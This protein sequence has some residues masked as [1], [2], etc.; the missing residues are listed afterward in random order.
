MT[1]SNPTE[2]IGGEQNRLVGDLW[3][4]GG[5]PVILL[6]GGGQTR[7]AWDR[8]AMRLRAAGMRAITVDQRGHGDSEWV[9]SRDYSFGHFAEDCAA[10][11]RQVAERYHA[12]PSVVG[13]SLGG[14]AAL[15]AELA[16]GPLFE[17]LVLVD[18]TPR[19]DPQGVARIQG[20]MAE[21][22]DEGFAT[23]EE[24]AD[25]IA[26]YLP[27]RK[28]PA[29]LDGLRKN[30]RLCPDGRYRWHWDPAFMNEV[31]GINHRSEA[32]TADLVAKLPRLHIPVLLVRGMHSEV[33]TEDLAREFLTQAPNASSIDVGEA[34]HMVA[35][36]RNDVFADAVLAFLAGEEVAG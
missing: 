2:F 1:R 32:F 16:Y 18:V 28:R 22:M 5:S 14:L 11:A 7:H 3:D 25:A 12:A 27:N 15:G 4:G 30:L 6:H 19:L 8:T 29:S 23:L 13:A 24:A 36:D 10:I 26:R 17:S 9:P 21:R 34:G 20:F 35:G 33:V 31:T